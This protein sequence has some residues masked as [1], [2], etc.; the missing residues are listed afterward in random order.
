VIDCHVLVCVFRISTRVHV[1]IT[2]SFIITSHSCCSRA[3]HDSCMSCPVHTCT[4]HAQL[5]PRGE[6]GGGTRFFLPHK[7]VHF[8]TCPNSQSQT[9][10]TN[11][12]KIDK[13]P[14]HIQ[15]LPF[16]PAQHS[17]VSDFSTSLLRSTHILYPSIH[18][19]S[20]HPSIHPSHCHRKKRSRR[21]HHKRSTQ[22][23][24]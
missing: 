5:I 22:H 8:S 1:I 10:L 21:N 11:R 6:G 23:Q 12:K 15:I 20:I 2:I 19:I 14:T 18:H 17:R 3:I 16:C 4:N 24:L 7:H 13:G 9:K